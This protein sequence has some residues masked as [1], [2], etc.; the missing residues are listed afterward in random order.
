MRRKSKEEEGKARQGKVR[1]REGRRSGRKT[2]DENG[3]GMR[4]GNEEDGEKR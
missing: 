2:I 1:E 3:E 4:R